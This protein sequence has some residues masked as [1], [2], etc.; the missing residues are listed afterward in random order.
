MFISCFS[1]WV[2]KGSIHILCCE[3][4]DDHFEVL[5]VIIVI[6]SNISYVFHGKVLVLV[7]F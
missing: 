5:V 6:G 1:F 7:K 2:L 3:Y 4:F